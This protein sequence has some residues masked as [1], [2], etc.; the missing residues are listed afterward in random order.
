MFQTKSIDY[1]FTKSGDIAVSFTVS[2]SERKAF[3][4]FFKKIKKDRLYDVEIKKHQNKRS[5]NANKYMW[6]LCQKIADKL[7]E[8]QGVT[9]TKEDIYRSS[10]R[11]IGVY[12][13]A[14]FDEKTARTFR[15]AWERLGTGWI[16]ENVDF[17]SDGGITVRFYYGSST[18]N[19]KQMSKLINNLV[20]ECKTLE[21]ETVSPEELKSMIENWTFLR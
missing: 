7:T 9:H 20:E 14:E 8:E 11:D 19:T 21:I 3:E 2:K 5:Q 1:S 17:I 18:Y 4:C 13:D 15:T 12:R 16:T 10:I 6:I